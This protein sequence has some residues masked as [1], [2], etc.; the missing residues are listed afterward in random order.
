M[1]KWLKRLAT[2]LV[3]VEDEPDPV[4]PCHE[5]VG[6]NKSQVT[7]YV[8]T[9]AVGL[10]LVGHPMECTEGECVRLLGPGDALDPGRWFTLFRGYCPGGSVSHI[11]WDNGTPVDLGG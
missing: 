8:I 9:G 5:W 6:Q 1:L 4:L 3:G 10:R 2:W 7:I 11:H